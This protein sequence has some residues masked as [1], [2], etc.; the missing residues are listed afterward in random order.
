VT[1]AA[2]LGVAL[3]ASV[4]L[5]VAPEELAPEATIAV[6]AGFLATMGFVVARLDGARLGPAVRAGSLIVVVGA[7][8]V[9]IKLLVA[10]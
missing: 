5:L 7:I 1:L 9:A 2:A 3:V 10:Y 8:V 6:L 4:P